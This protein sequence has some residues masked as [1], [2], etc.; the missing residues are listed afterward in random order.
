M[1]LSIFLWRLPENRTLTNNNVDDACKECGKSR[2]HSADFTRVFSLIG[3][4]KRSRNFAPFLRP[5]R[6]SWRV[7]WVH[8]LTHCWRKLI[9]RR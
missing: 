2:V 5:T 1:S 7:A 8:Y 4:N 6:R 3:E 9:A